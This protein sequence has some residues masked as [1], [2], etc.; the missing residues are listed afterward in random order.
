MMQYWCSLICVFLASV[1]LQSQAQL[2]EVTIDSSTTSIPAAKANTATPSTLAVTNATKQ[3]GNATNPVVVNATDVVAAI[4]A[5]PFANVTNPVGANVTKPVAIV[6][7]L[8]VAN[9]TKPIEEQAKLVLSTTSAAKAQIVIA[10]SGL[11]TPQTNGANSGTETPEAPA[12]AISHSESSR[13]GNSLVGGM[14]LS[15][16]TA[17]REQTPLTE[18]PGDSVAEPQPK[19]VV[20]KLVQYVEEEEAALRQH[21]A[22]HGVLMLI[23]VVMLVSFACLIRRS[24]SKIST[25]PK[26]RDAEAHDIEANVT[27]ASKPRTAK[28]AK[29]S[30]VAKESSISRSSTRS[31][32]DEWEEDKGE[33]SSAEWS[34]GWTEN[35]FDDDGSPAARSSGHWGGSPT[36]AEVEACAVDPFGFKGSKGKAD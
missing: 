8:L 18:A 24:V 15:S 33:D 27:N 30:E 1:G 4:V 20:M 6:T 12:V 19:F 35:P 5:Q 36:L 26:K 3:V 28:I 10:N 16:P 23:A 2:T 31:G 17:N 7:N 29:T 9:E 25:A 21:T 34:T 32:W 14:P 13:I 22:G 11:E